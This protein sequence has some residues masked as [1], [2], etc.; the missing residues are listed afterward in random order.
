[1]AEKPE[2]TEKNLHEGHRG[3]MLENYL[4]N[5]LDGFSDVQALEFLLN[6]ALARI[7]T[8]TIAHRLLE[9]FG[10]LHQVFEAP[11]ELLVQVE[12][13]RSQRIFRTTEEIGRFL[14]AKIG[15]YREERAFLMSL[16]LDCKLLDFREL[17]R[18]SVDSVNLPYRKVVEAALMNNA[19]TVI[20]AHNHLCDTAVP[21]MSDIDY[22]KQIFAYLQKLDIV[23]TD[24]II[25][26]NHFYY[27]MKL[28]GM[29]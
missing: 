12:G 15:Q 11:I 29:I 5:G 3:R 21:S 28:S 23:L 1:M 7:D 4:K 27:S 20:L 13:V 18:G 26:A 19:A 2:K 9:E 24:H 17:T 22:T 10:S 14:V 8:N 6:Y 25:V 16:D